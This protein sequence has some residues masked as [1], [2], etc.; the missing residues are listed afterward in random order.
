M[1]V[2]AMKSY[3]A[4]ARA[5]RQKHADAA[6]QSGVEVPLA[7]DGL[8]MDVFERAELEDCRKEPLMS[9]LVKAEGKLPIPKG[10]MSP[11][12]AARA[13]KGAEAML[14]GRLAA[15]AR[16]ARDDAVLESVKFCHECI[17][18]DWGASTK[19]VWETHASTSVY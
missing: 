19:A 18:D 8:P 15:M 14:R 1:S 5:A 2:A 3:V 13:S 9:Q 17:D 10:N 11:S 16:L 7:S 4:E 6:G 12:K